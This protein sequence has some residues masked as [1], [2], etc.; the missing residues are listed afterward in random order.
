MA[1]ILAVPIF[2]L[3]A[4]LQSSIISRI[5]L[6]QG[7][8]DLVLLVLIAWALQDRVKH[9]WFWAVLGGALMNYLSG[10]PVPI[11]LI[12]YMV[13][14]IGVRLVIRRIWQVPLLMMLV[15]TTIGTIL[16]LGAQYLTRVITGVMLPFGDSLSLVILPSVFLNLLFSIP[17]YTL[18]TDFANWV[19]PT[20]KET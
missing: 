8:A 7:S 19:Y 10:L 11:L 4:I 17:V 12:T 14:V 16:L 20:E 3:L 5:T 1:T 6:L 9:A 18:V 15:G 2:L 13:I